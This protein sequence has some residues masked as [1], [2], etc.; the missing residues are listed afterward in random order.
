[1]VLIKRRKSNIMKQVKKVVTNHL[2]KNLDRRKT[3]MKGKRNKNQGS[4][5]EMYMPGIVVYGI[6]VLLVAGFV[7]ANHYFPMMLLPNIIGVAIILSGLFYLWLWCRQ[8]PKKKII[9]YMSVEIM[10]M[11]CII[12]YS[13]FATNVAQEKIIGIM[14]LGYLLFWVYVLWRDTKGKKEK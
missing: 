11:L 10:G 6:L 3:E 14:C 2:A 7:I 12:L 13:A 8:K 4:L 1:M 9:Q 5:W